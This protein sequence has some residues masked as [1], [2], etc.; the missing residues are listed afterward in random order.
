MITLDANTASEYDFVVGLDASGSM[1]SPSKR[2]PGKTRW[3]EAQETIFGISSAVAKYDSDGIDLV[4]FGGGV[5]SYEGVTPDK[6]VDVFNSRSPRGSTPL[7]DAL[8]WVASKHA[9]TGKNTVAIILTDGEPDDRGLAEKVIVDAS[10]TLDK[11][12]GLTFLFVQVGDDPGAHA[13]LEHLDNGLAS[14]KFDIVCALTAKDADQ[15]EPLDLINHA[16][17]N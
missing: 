17:N 16:I 15:M 14:A 10:N 2:F 3:N 7:H 1:A 6:V 11:D 9:R 8:G 12:E 5:Q 13:Y 4:V